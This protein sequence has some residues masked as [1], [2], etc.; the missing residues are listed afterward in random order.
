MQK[1]NCTSVQF[2]EYNKYLKYVEP[3]IKLQQIQD[4]EY[5]EGLLLSNENCRG[6]FSTFTSLGNCGCLKLNCLTGVSLD[7]EIIYEM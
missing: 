3:E 6:V 5:S 2:S 7:E 1:T 4:L